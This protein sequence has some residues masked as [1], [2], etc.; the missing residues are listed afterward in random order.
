MKKIYFFLFCFLFLSLSTCKR[1]QNTTQKTSQQRQPVSDNLPEIISA[2][3]SWQDEQIKVNSTLSISIKPDYS[4]EPKIKKLINGAENIF[5][6]T[7]QIKIGNDSIGSYRAFAFL[8]AR[9]KIMSARIVEIYGNLNYIQENKDRVLNSFNDY[10]IS[11]FSGA[12]FTYDIFYRPLRNRNYK[13]GKVIAAN[14]GFAKNYTSTTN[15][16]KTMTNNL[17]KVNCSQAAYSIRDSLKVNSDCFDVYWVTEYADGRQSWVYLY[18]YCNCDGGGAGGGG[19]TGSISPINSF[20]GFPA[21]PINGQVFVYVSDTNVRTEFTYNTNL[22]IWLAP[23]VQIL[24]DQGYSL[25]YETQPPSFDPS[26][27]LSAFAIPA[28]VD[29]TQV[30]KVVIVGTAIVLTTVYVYE[31]AKWAKSRQNDREALCQSYLVPCLNDYYYYDCRSCY[32]YCINE[33]QWYESLCPGITTGQQ[34]Y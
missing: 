3:K 19:G 6:E 16:L 34:D 4:I 17:I 7:T 14:S 32:N 29:P 18:S 15:G 10:K 30:S 27:I 21:N 24:V 25:A 11:G 23:E 31:F 9:G 2:V 22:T 33:G 5:F 8:R 26:C 13:D 20:K 12:I 1:E 28:L